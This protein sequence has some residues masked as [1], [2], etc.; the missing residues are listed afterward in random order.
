LLISGTLSVRS[1]SVSSPARVDI[2]GR[3]EI[4]VAGATRYTVFEADG[5][6]KWS[7]VTEDGSSAATGS[8]VFDFEGDESEAQ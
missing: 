3:P 1:L 8:S 2:A 5:S 4:G 7:R 6:I